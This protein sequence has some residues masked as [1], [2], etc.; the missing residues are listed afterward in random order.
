MKLVMFDVDGTLTDTFSAEDNGFVTAVRDVL[1]VDG[2]NTDWTSYPHA[3]L[4]SMLDEI[5][6]AKLGR[7]PFAEETRAVQARFVALLQAAVRR[8]AGAIR[9]IPGAASFVRLLLDAGYAVAIASGDWELSAR[10]KLT[11][12]A[13]PVDGLPAVFADSARTRTEIMQTSLQL[14]DRHYGGGGFERVVYVGDGTWD[15]QATRVLGWPFAGIGSGAR[16]AAL[17]SMGARHVFPDY[18]R[19]DDLIAAIESPGPPIA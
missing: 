14:A 18:T 17:R 19:P 9:A 15:I 8:D 10:F 1:G 12:A 2:I 16:G 3:T 13:I 5:S 6:R 7:A 4:S 11:V